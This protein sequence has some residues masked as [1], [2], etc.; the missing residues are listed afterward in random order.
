MAD[1]DNPVA[2]AG[3]LLA[4]PIGGAIAGV[5]VGYHNRTCY[6]QI[7]G[8]CAA[9]TYWTFDKSAAVPA[10]LLGW[11]L[12]GCYYVYQSM[13]ANRNAAN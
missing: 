6:S 10:T 3:A 9:G 2:W 12:T 11:G 7:L 13:K 4:S 1:D 5:A 8:G